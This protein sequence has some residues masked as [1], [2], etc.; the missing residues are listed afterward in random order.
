MGL[1]SYISNLAIG[2]VVP[3]MLVKLGK[4]QTQNMM[5]TARDTM[6]PTR[7]PVA[8]HGVIAVAVALAGAFGLEL[9]AEQLSVTIS[10]LVAIGTFIVRGRVSPVDR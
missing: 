3:D 2:G 8:W 6:K 4:C 9:T 5:T 7:E 10:T 1:K